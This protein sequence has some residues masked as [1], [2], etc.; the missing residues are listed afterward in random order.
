MKDT[1]GERDGNRIK[2][3]GAINK[4]DIYC[5][6]LYVGAVLNRESGWGL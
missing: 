2:V 5:R 6:G 1:I 4:G 3:Q